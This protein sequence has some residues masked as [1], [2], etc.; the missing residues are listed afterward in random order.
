MILPPAKLTEVQQHQLTQINRNEELRTVYLLSQEFVTLLKERREEVLDSW[1]RRA[2]ASQVR[3]LSSFVNGLRRDDAAVRAACRLPWSN[4]PTEG[5]SNRLK[6]LKRQ[7]L[8][9]L[10]STCSV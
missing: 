4:G 6:F 3:E 7:C 10:I 2:K 5:H 8:V 9:A 1:Q